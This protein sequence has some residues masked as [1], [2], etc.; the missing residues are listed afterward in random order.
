VVVSQQ[1]CLNSEINLGKAKNIDDLKKELIWMP[2]APFSRSD[3][4]LFE[5]N[6]GCPRNYE[7]PVV[8]RDDFW[9]VL[10][11]F[12]PIFSQTSIFYTH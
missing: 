7:T 10:I 12:F 3:Y 8:F 11:S 5:K 6:Q 1:G 2:K 9:S 4:V